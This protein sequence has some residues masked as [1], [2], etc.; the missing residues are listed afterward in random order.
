[1][2]LRFPSDLSPNPLAALLAQKRAQGIGVLDLTESN[3]TLV[4]FH[5]PED[6]ITRALSSPAILRY[7]PHPRGAIETRMAVAE[8]FRTRGLA[9]DPDRIHLTASS[10]ESYSFL[11]KLLTQPGDA[12]LAP[13]PSYPLV[14]H[15]AAMEAVETI[16]YPIRRA[17]GDSW[18]IDLLALEHAW[19]PNC[20]AIVVI[21][22]N[23]PTGNYLQ[24]EESDSL[25][26]FCAERDMAIISDEVFFFYPLTT[27]I[28]EIP[29]D[30]V[31]MLDATSSALAFTLG[32]LSKMLALPQLKLGWI[33]S[34]GPTDLLETALERLDLIADTY[35][36]VNTPVQQAARD[37][38]HDVGGV[39]AQIRER[40]MKN[41]DT[42]TRASSRFITSRVSP[43]DAGWSAIL[44][45]DDDV[46]EED[47]VLRLLSEYDVLVHPGF[48]F[49]FNCG[50][51]I[52]LSLLPPPERFD[53][54]LRRIE[55]FMTLARI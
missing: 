44:H 50:S 24:R 18:G 23:N 9:M 13:S 41:L 53:E 43:P 35:L 46:D 16:P 49:D 21:N 28:P 37:L 54:G 5:Y 3:P 15:L 32:G 39:Q 14:E 26:R 30:A 48:F 51:H 6:H 17:D 52:V 20:K 47:L 36:S 45:I 22:P 29:H 55:K 4:G 7:E 19:T 11:F 1:M 27:T 10:S 40:C 25:V 12:V 8:Y 2:K 33:A 38:L 31:S 34:A 42:L